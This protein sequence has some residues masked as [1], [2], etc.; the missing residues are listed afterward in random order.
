[1]KRIVLF[2]E[3]EGDRQAVPVLV[4]RI[5]ADTA[6]WDDVFVDTR[7]FRVGSVG[8]LV[9]DD[10]ADR[11]RLLQAAARTRSSLGGILLLLDGDI[12]VVGGVPF[13]AKRVA[14]RLAQQARRAGAGSLFSVA[15]VFACREYESWLIAGVASLAGKIPPA[16]DR[17][18]A[19]RD[20][21]GWL[22]RAMPGGY[23]AARDQKCLT[24][25]VDLRAI[26]DRQMRS[27]Q[28]LDSAIAE[29]VDAVRD[30]APIST[31]VLT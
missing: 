28:R 5:L 13:C 22:S 15:V 20:A 9:R 16:G 7:P 26:R 8:K 23:R 18:W 2:V 30:D 17:E 4:N 25:L 3:G 10:C 24:Q 1:M 19:P 27:F 29:L 12:E 11:T 6:A 21:K 31:P 14:A